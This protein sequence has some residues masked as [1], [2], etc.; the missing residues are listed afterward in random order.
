MKHISE[1]FTEEEF[2]RLQAGKG[3]RSWRE[4]MLEEIATEHELIQ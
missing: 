3:D 2:E 4:A 1:Q